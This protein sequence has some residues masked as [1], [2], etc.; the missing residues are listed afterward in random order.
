[1]AT[2]QAEEPI[3]TDDLVVAASAARLGIGVGPLP[4]APAGANNDGEH[5][6]INREL[7][8]L[9]YYKRAITIAEDHGTP[10]LE[11]AKFLAIF[12]GL[13]DDYFEMR[14]AALKDQLTTV[15]SGTD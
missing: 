6:Y 15:L 1:M 10:L 2:T 13:F 9:D 7:S 3:S 8:I 14:V 5:R 4:A 11:R 12:N